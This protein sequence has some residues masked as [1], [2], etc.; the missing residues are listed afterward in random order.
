VGQVDERDIIGS[1]QRVGSC[2]HPASG[3]GQAAA[4]MQNARELGDERSVKMQR[5]AGQRTVLVCETLAIPA[6][7]GCAA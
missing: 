7:Q 6:T 4:G 5:S 2:G 1:E 3:S